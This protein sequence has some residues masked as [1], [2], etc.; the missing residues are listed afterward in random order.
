[1]RDLIIIGGGA[2][3]LAAAVYAQ[4]KQLNY[5]LI[6][7]T[8]GKAAAMPWSNTVGAAVTQLFADRLAIAPEHLLVDRATLVRRDVIGFT[9]ETEQRHAPQALAVVIATG[10]QPVRLPVAASGGPTRYDL[11]YSVTTHAQH[12]TG[13]DVAII[14]ATPRSLRGAHE[15][16]SIASRIYMVVELTNAF[17]TPM[18]I[19][20]KYQPNV[21]LLEGYRVTG[22]THESDGVK[23][24]VA[25]A[26][27][28]IERTLAVDAVFADLGL[29]PDSELVQG[30]L[31]TDSNGFIPVDDVGATARPGL[32]AAG[33]VTTA[34]AEQVL[35]AVG[36]GAR[37][38]QSAYEYILAHASMR[39]VAAN[40]PA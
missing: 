27:G 19:G 28:S 20:I 35:F 18:G 26:R 6:A 14:G 21:E 10:V 4:E 32:F 1:M 37:A 2:A 9:V 24:M 7:P 3:G 11:G 31:V 23:V 40:K 33:D 5:L 17:M 30:L 34:L 29:R 25:I 22:V 39:E 16:A 38:A 15:L 12:M 13:K 36:Q 8:P